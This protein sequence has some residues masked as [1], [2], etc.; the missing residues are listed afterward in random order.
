LLTIVSGHAQI[1]KRGYRE[2]AKVMRAIDAIDMAAK[3]GVTLTRQLL[4]FSR[5]QRLSPER[6]DLKRRVEDFRGMLANSVPAQSR[7]Q[8][9][10]DDE[11]WPVEVDAAELERALLNVALN[12]R[13][14]MPTGGSITIAARNVRLERSDLQ[15]E[16]AG[17]FVALSIAD[18][19]TGIPEDVL[20]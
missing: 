16:I 18:T 7:M 4:S 12:A 6:I 19:G 5:Q 8:I 9:G 20:P 17:D 10:I 14:A 15:A 13:D 1:I 3:R 11:V 2:D